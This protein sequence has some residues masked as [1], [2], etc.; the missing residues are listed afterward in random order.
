M[1]RDPFGHQVLAA[2]VDIDRAVGL[3]LHIDVDDVREIGQGRIA[4]ID[5]T[6]G[7]IARI[8]AVL[9][10]FDLDIELGDLVDQAIDIA[11]LAGDLIV[12]AGPRC[13]TCVAI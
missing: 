13:S 8:G 6:H 3:L 7:L 2:G 4:L 9:K 12:E 1:L 5:Q 11:G 10:A